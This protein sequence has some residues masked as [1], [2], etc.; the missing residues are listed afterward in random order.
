[1]AVPRTYDGLA[2]PLNDMGLESRSPSAANK[3][4]LGPG[5]HSP[6]DDPDLEA[7]APSSRGRSNKLPER[8][9]NDGTR[10]REIFRLRALN[11]L[12]EHLNESSDVR[13]LVDGALSILREVLK[14]KAAWAYIWNTAGLRLPAHE[15]EH[16]EHDFALVGCQGL[17]GEDMDGNCRHLCKPPDCACQAMLRAGA[18][19]KGVNIVKCT[20]LQKVE[21]LK[22]KPGRPLFHA[23][24]PLISRSG[25]LGIINVAT[26]AWDRV[27]EPDLQLLTSAGLQIASA[28]ERA[29]S[30]EAVEEH[31]AHLE[32][33]LE[34]ARTVQ[35]ALVPREIPAIKGFNLASEWRSAREMAGDF[36]DIIKL[37]EGKW[38]VVV[39]DV[40]GKGAPAAMYMA[41]IRS[42]IRSE[43]D[44][45]SRPSA[46]LKAVNQILRADSVDEM[47]VTVF[48]GVLDSNA[49]TFE[50]FNAG[51]DPPL[52]RHANGRIERL[53]FGSLFTKG[54]PQMDDITL[55]VLNRK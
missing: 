33:E 17:P 28:I 13:T 32:H 10:E 31:R 18:L 16:D 3:P 9:Q 25:R 5:R 53:P 26:E 50:Y 36:F 12:A 45:D 42:I 37:P 35:R 40:S 44:R 1:M 27:P 24:V 15:C 49:E 46:V 55:L 7:R 48:F 22:T 8:G 23:T 20:R 11:C 14:A 51:H 2:T 6:A 54:A 38:G 34:M 19:D 43:A 4:G 39:A 29:R 30:Y 21:E 52:L 47:F 41:M